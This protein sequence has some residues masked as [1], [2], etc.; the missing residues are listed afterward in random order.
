MSYGIE[1]LNN[2]DRIVI[3][4]NYPN[5]GF[6]SNLNTATPNSAYPGV[7]NSLSSDL[8]FARANTNTNGI[9]ARDYVGTNWSKSLVSSAR[10]YVCRRFDAL[11]ISANSNY[12]IAV[13]NTSSNVTFYSNIERN[14]EIVAVGVLNSNVSNSINIAFP[15]ATTWYSDFSKYYCLVNGTSTF[16]LPHAPP[17]VVGE[18]IRIRYNCIWANSTHGRIIFESYNLPGGVFTPQKINKD[19]CYMIVKELS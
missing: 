15:S 14:F 9:L 10:Y 8:V 12:G 2:N 16:F 1:V 11:G 17:Y 19:S 5:I 4:L 6:F 7:A 18:D 3:D 13:Y